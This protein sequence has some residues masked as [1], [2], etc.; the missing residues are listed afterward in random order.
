MKEIHAV[1]QQT[2]LLSTTSE[3]LWRSSVSFFYVYPNFNWFMYRKNIDLI[4]AR[5]VYL[6]FVE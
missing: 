5:D 2:P 1:G 4:N 3:A 6:I